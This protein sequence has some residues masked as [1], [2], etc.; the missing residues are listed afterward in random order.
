MSTPDA[1]NGVK[2]FTLN[3]SSRRMSKFKYKCRCE[4]G[5]DIASYMKD[6]SEL[7]CTSKYCGVSRTLPGTD[8]E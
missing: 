1:S 7:F 3:N 4:S 8:K 2:G 6:N 5:V